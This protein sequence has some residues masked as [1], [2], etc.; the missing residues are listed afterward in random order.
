MIKDGSQIRNNQTAQK[1]AEKRKPNEI[2]SG[3]AKVKS[4]K[5]K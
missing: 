2:I 5:V 4:K 1:G 3:Q